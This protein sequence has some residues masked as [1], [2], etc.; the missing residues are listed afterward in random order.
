MAPVKRPK[1]S[2]HGKHTLLPLVVAVVAVGGGGVV[3]VVVVVV[4]VVVVGVVVVV[5]ME[6]AE[7]HLRWK[8][9][10]H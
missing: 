7:M 6:V 4:R 5:V 10:L 2:Y 1:S 8:R 3:A 9:S